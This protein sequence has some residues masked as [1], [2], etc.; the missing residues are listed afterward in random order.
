MKSTRL[1]TEDIDRLFRLLDEELGKK[2]ILGEC[3]VVGGAAMC[4]A[5]DA[6]PATQDVDAY[7]R[8]AAEVR[9][10]AT[11]V[12]NRAGV[13]DGWLNDGVKEFLGDRAQFRPF[14]E[15]PH[16]RIFVAEPHYLLAMKCMATRIGE[17]F[18]DLDDI[19]YL[20]RHLSIETATDALD[21]VRRYFDDDRIPVKTRLAL[22][23][24]LGRR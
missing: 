18:H 4:L 5:L 21:I 13:S 11:R 1:T 10:A 7:F 19:R 20:L 16:L 23:E 17:E 6:R 15:L 14:L 8:P 24:I 12:A 2:G 3:H 22:E 9:A